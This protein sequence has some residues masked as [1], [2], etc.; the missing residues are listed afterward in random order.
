M[1]VADWPKLSETLRFE[2]HPLC[3]SN[4][5]Q[6][7]ATGAALQRWRECDGK[8]QPT[9]TIVLLCAPCAR[10]LIEPAPRLYVKVDANAPLLGT[11]EM[12]AECRHRK[13]LSC[14]N[15]LT[16]A[17]GGPGL[18]LKVAEPIR[19]FQDG[20]DPKTRKRTGGPFEIWPSPPSSCAG[21]D[22][23]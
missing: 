3:C 23:A 5:G 7:P 16:K 15:P 4:C 14:T 17:N 12:C 19:G 9:Q 1:N 22:V 2:R 10:R 18:I 21:R 8:D 13:M 20:Q 6:G 11:M